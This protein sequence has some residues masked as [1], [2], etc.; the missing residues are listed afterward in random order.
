MARVHHGHVATHGRG[1][2]INLINRLGMLEGMDK[3]RYIDA[4]A[5]R[6]RLPESSDSMTASSWRLRLTTCTA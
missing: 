5:V 4:L 3:F 2:V 6:D 1:L